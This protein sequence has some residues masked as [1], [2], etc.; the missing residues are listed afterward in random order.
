M[1]HWKWV[2]ISTTALVVHVWLLK[3]SSNFHSE[4]CKSNWKANIICI[5]KTFSFQFQ[6]MNGPNKHLLNENHLCTINQ[7]II[8]FDVWKTFTSFTKWEKYLKTLFS[9]VLWTKLK[10]AK[11]VKR[12]SHIA[13]AN[14]ISRKI[15]K[16]K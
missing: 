14:C 13:N 15:E 12:R 3:S 9:S 11:R 8:L 16:S 7:A 4:N 1:T 6:E 10:L 2:F 5:N